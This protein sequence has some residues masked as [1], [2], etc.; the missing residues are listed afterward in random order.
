MEQR[1]LLLLWR[2]VAF[3]LA[4]TPRLTSAAAE[5]I[6]IG[7][8]VKS[9]VERSHWKPPLTV[10]MVGTVKGTD[11][12][13]IP[14][15]MKWVVFDGDPPVKGMMEIEDLQKVDQATKGVELLQSGVKLTHS[16]AWGNGG[17]GGTE[18]GACDP[19]SQQTVAPVLLQKSVLQRRSIVDEAD[20]ST[21]AH[22]SPA[23]DEKAPVS[24]VAPAAGASAFPR[25]P[26]HL[27]AQ[28]TPA[29][30]K[31]AALVQGEVVVQKV[32][33]E[34]AEAAPGAAKEAVKAVAAPL[35]ASKAAART[36]GLAATK[37]AA[38]AAAPPQAA[39]SYFSEPH[40]HRVISG[41]LIGPVGF[42]QADYEVSMADK[43]A[44]GT[45]DFAAT[46]AHVEYCKSWM[47]NSKYSFVNN[48]SFLCEF[49]A[50]FLGLLVCT[51]IVA[52]SVAA[53]WGI[54]SGLKS[55]HQ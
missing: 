27:L 22:E 31:G 2:G 37:P 42:G 7:A 21:P 4:T 24:S 44:V 5:D 17:D 10:G 46:G 55:V 34:Q 36:G 38:K 45:L 32:S 49:G 9:K 1:F 12:M 40:R 39:A 48:N 25:T 8:R 41:A 30:D 33:A 47:H 50:I 51:P 29:M 16:C 35:A 20:S 54:V 14:E 19:S 43:V 3:L 18:L 15:G 6:R 13:K 28:K 11:D 26:A 53:F 52:L 23:K